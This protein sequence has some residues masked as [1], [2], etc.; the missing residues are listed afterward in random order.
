[1]ERHDSSILSSSDLE[2][3]SGGLIV[4]GGPVLTN[5]AS[6][7]S[8]LLGGPVVTNSILNTSAYGYPGYGD[9][10]LYGAAGY[11][12]YAYDFAGYPPVGYGYD[13]DAPYVYGGNGNVM[14]ANLVGGA[15]GN[16]VRGLV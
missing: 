6:Y 14:A 2:T 9:Y 11:D 10:G 3:V 8:P 5:Y 4:G 1:M 16:L 15:I 12:P 13:F 7:G